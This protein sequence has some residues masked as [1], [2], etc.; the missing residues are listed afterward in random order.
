MIAT[1]V[2]PWNTRT[3]VYQDIDILE[4]IARARPFRASNITA[5]DLARLA[6]REHFSFLLNGWNEIAEVHSEGA[7]RRCC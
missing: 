4:F 7:I 3:I 5:G 1:S 2:R 6:E